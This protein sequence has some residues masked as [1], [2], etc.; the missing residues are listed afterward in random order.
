MVFVCFA[1][2][3]VWLRLAMLL[4]GLLVVGVFAF[5][6]DVFVCVAMK[7]VRVLFVVYCVMLCA[8]VFVCVLVSVRVFGMCRCAAFVVYRVTVNG[9][10]VCFV[11]VYACVYTVCVF[12][13]YCM[14]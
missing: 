10:V 14:A 2:I 12:C 1:A 5:V 8:C 6:P 13:V 7:C 11:C 4:Y 3:C 9:G